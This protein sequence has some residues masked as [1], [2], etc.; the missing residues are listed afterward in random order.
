MND[1]RLAAFQALAAVAAMY[2]SSDTPRLTVP[3][4]KREKSPSQT[5]GR[6]NE[7]PTSEQC[8]QEMLQARIRSLPPLYTKTP[9]NSKC[10]CGS[11]KKFKFCCITKRAG[12]LH[13]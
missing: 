10:P 12:D 5:E 4:T 6:C 7:A 1:Q 11:G 2:A 3:R 8:Q 13:G 9:R